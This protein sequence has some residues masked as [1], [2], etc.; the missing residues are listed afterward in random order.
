[1]RSL[2]TCTC[3]AEVAAAHEG[4]GCG[5]VPACAG[6]DADRLH[7]GHEHD[8]DPWDPSIHL[9]DEVVE[10]DCKLLEV[11]K[12]ADR[13]EELAGTGQGAPTGSK[14]AQTSAAEAY[15]PATEAVWVQCTLWAGRP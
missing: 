4:D 15:A 3:G 1:M 13:V 14:P 10:L 12:C 6:V 8:L 5:E 2:I 9:L 11:L 7:R